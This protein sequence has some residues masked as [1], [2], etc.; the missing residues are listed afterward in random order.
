VSFGYVELI[1]F[2]LLVR[3]AYH[4]LKGI[5]MSDFEIF[6]AG[7]AQF[8]RRGRKASIDEKLVEALSKL[9]KGKAMALKSLGQDPTAPTFGNDKARIASQIRT[10]CKLA[11]V[12]D[13]SILWSPTGVP[14]VL[15]K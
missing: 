3:T 9:P 5:I 11:G 15:R 7:D 8:V 4:K 13:F 1:V 14:Q 6:D 2:L 10:A 12:K